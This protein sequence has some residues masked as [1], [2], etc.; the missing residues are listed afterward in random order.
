[1]TDSLPA[2]VTEYRRWR[3]APPISGTD[4]CAHT[5]ITAKCFPTS[6]PYTTVTRSRRTASFS[7][8]APT[9]SVENSLIGGGLC[10]TPPSPAQR[11]STPRS[12]WLA[13]KSEEIR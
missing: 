4:W 7:V 12:V 8:I 1:M 13:C 5:L 3:E 2:Y 9:R 10:A 6:M 11:P